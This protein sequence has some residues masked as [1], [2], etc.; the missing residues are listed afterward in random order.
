RLELR[1]QTWAMRAPAGFSADPA[2]VADLAGA[3]SHA[4]ADA[5]IAERDD[6]SFGFDGPAS[7]TVTLTLGGDAGHADARRV[8]LIFGAEG[9]GGVYAHT[10][11][12]PAV[13]IAPKVVREL[14]SRPAVDRSRL[15]I[16][17]GA[18]TSATL[19]R[20]SARLVLERS[21][22]RLVRLPRGRDAAGDDDKLQTALS[23]FYALA[24]LH[25]GPP[26]RDEGM[27]RPTLEITARTLAAVGGLHEIRVSVG[28]QAHLGA[29][30]VYFARAA[31]IDA[32]FAVPA[33]AVTAILG[34]W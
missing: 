34:A 1:G 7:C 8:S 33:G 4:K 14:A 25:T 2:S 32:T 20:D 10:L 15:R 21:G 26:A 13:F 22:D 11:G 19:G 16:D 29:E 28:G 5:W 12:D 18:L 23:G 31:G 6:G 3:I 17:P 27:D 24:A 9:D 30:D